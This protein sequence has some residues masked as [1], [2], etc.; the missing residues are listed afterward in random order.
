MACYVA[1][2]AETKK[3]SSIERALVA[4][5]KAHEVA[6]HA[7]PTDAR[8][9]REAMKGIRRRK[10]VAQKKAAPLLASPL[11][12]IV[13]TLDLDR[14]KDLRD[15][16]L[17]CLGFTTGMRRSE[18]VALDCED[19]RPNER[20][21]SITIRRSKTDQEG[22]GR[23]VA[24]CYGGNGA[25]PVKAVSEWLAAAGIASGP[26]FVE[27]NRHGKASVGKRLT[28]QVVRTVVKSRAEAAGIVGFE[29][30]SGHSLRAG[31]AT[32]AALNGAQER[33][34]AKQTGHKSEKIL[35]GYIRQ[36][37]LWQ[38]NVTEGLL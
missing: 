10:T 16:A 6:G 5:R 13:A 20:G 22:A 1:D 21:A 24:V 12:T 35:R 36:A 9:V 17:L 31:L 18:L 7:D 28:A 14:L 33:D 8:V 4:I 38:N 34:I 29:N 15:R 37:D 30:L 23:E 26:V 25:C 32:Q 2:L 27:V 11:K 3:V 19:I